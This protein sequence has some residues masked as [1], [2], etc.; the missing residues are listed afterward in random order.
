MR[1]SRPVALPH[2]PPSR[3]YYF[4]ASSLSDST[5]LCFCATMI[6]VLIPPVF[7][8][9]VNI[10]P[11]SF[12]PGTFSASPSACVLASFFATSFYHFFDLCD[13]IR[14]FSQFFALPSDLCHCILFT[15]QCGYHLQSCLGLFSLTGRFYQDLWNKL[16]WHY[17]WAAPGCL[18]LLHH[19]FH[20]GHKLLHKDRL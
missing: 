7:L 15:C 11:F 14:R 12:S 17:H 1:C 20:N 13:L 2:L 16:S 18:C 6:L 4:P 10:S 3:W 8:N 9:S 19:R 5:P